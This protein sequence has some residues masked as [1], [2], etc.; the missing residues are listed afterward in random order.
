MN[1]ARRAPITRIATLV[2]IVAAALAG[3]VGRH[4]AL[5]DLVDAAAQTDIR[6][7][8]GYLAGFP[9]RPHSRVRNAGAPIDIRSY[10]LRKVAADILVAD[11][12]EGAL[13]DEPH[14]AGVADLIVGKINDSIALLE[15]A[16]ASP[17]ASAA[18]WNDLAVALLERGLRK[19]DPESVARAIGA[20]THALDVDPEIPEALFNRSLA[21]G[22]LGLQRAAALD[23]VAYLQRDTSSGWA[24]ELRRHLP[25]AIRSHS[26]EW[27]RA[28]A[29]LAAA[30]K[31]GD[32]QTITTIVRRFPQDSRT[33]G[34]GFFL[35]LWADGAAGD[36]AAAEES[37][38]L[39]RRIG[40]VLRDTSGESMLADAVA[41]IDAALACGDA[42]RV[43]ALARGHQQYREG[44]KRYSERKVL[45]SIP[46]FVA[47]LASFRRGN[48]P[49]SLLAEEYRA[50]ATF[51]AN[52]VEEA[53][54]MV[55]DL[56]RRI[57]QRYIAL[58]AQTAWHI[59]TFLANRGAVYE[60]LGSYDRA[61]SLFLTLGETWNAAQIAIYA[62][63][64][65]SW[66]G[67]TDEAWR[68]RR[69]A[70]HAASE[71]DS[72]SLL[73]S[74]LDDAAEGEF[75][76]GQWDIARALLT[77]AI[78]NTFDHTAKPNPRRRAHALTWRAVAEW[79]LGRETDAWQD[80][81]RGRA[82]ALAL[83]DPALRDAALCDLDVAEALLSR[84][85]APERAVALLSSTLAF[86]AAHRKGI[87]EPR[88]LLE[89]ARAYRQLGSD[90]AAT[91]D[92]MAAIDTV[93]KRGAA[94]DKGDVRDSFLGTTAEAYDEM[95]DLLVRRG[96]LE[97]AF[98]VA[99]RG[100][101]RLAASLAGIKPVTMPNV[102]DVAR[103]SRSLPR[104]GVM[105]HYTV[106]PHE[107]LALVVDSTS[108]R[109]VRAPVERDE[110]RQNVHNLLA[111]AE[112]RGDGAVAVESKW[113]Y[114]ALIAPIEGVISGARELI[115]VPDAEVANVPFSLLRDSAGRS[116]VERVITVKTPSATAYARASLQSPPTTAGKALIVG[117]P[118]FDTMRFPH[119]ERL[120]EAR[121]ESRAVADLYRPATLLT[122]TSATG[123]RFLAEA[124]NARL[125][126]LATHAVVDS[127][128]PSNSVLLFVPSPAN[129]T[130]SLSQIRS[131]PLRSD[132][133]VVLAGCRTAVRG[134]ASVSSFANAF[135]SAGAGTVIG[136]LWNVDDD[137]ARALGIRLHERLAAGQSPAVALRDTQIALLH[138]SDPALNDPRSWGAFEV[139]GT[140]SSVTEH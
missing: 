67:A 12:R 13:T 94:I 83:A 138:A 38:S 135:L 101:W 123:T 77:L 23:A 33:W 84:A 4:S 126:H 91:I 22:E 3:D 49:M 71:L 130:V 102:A 29:V 45:E 99:E 53:L 127:R 72:R 64:L 7:V 93:E 120:P 26:A 134:V 34:E 47:A 88:L 2:V 57:P 90:D 15:Q 68:V 121:E 96:Q 37:L 115:I 61:R 128:R 27:D 65:H 122:D 75:Q 119:L 95:V 44:R 113:L 82:V 139:V 137:A 54:D 133:V 43:A 105:V 55:R 21:Y 51:D 9:F 80:I 117:D 98:V 114:G 63:G 16:T 81:R 32:A 104:D 116:L 50:N 1:A 110:L 41:A 100:R 109:A 87:A 129:G 19:D 92:L 66:L 78:D 28:C 70:F 118:A 58:R 103:V 6:P 42:E 31:R 40:I 140:R 48:S 107:L 108:F 46:Y 124:P 36:A 24:D 125:I 79:R 60:G 59:G 11:E 89:R 52:Q 5:D 76:R 62:A 18:S 136:T 25:T 20:A 73:V 14:S 111:A 85:T 106:L 17:T 132:S 35:G 131:L 39:A 112:L 74:A 86:V 56:D 97:A 30:A 10:G 69:D 8:R